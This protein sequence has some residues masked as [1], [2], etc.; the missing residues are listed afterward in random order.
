MALRLDLR[1]RIPGFWE[2][3]PWVASAVYQIGLLFMTFFPSITIERTMERRCPNGSRKNNFGLYI[4]DV[5][6]CRFLD[7]CLNADNCARVMLTG[8]TGRNAPFHGL[9]FNHNTHRSHYPLP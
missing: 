3:H 2:R 7:V 8:G 6:L 1:D 9:P 5:H 4:S